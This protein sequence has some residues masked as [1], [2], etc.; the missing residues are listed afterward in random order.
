[1]IE[2]KNFFFCWGFG[3]P[4]CWDAGACAQ[5]CVG[6]RGVEKREFNFMRSMSKKKE[7]CF[8]DNVFANHSPEVMPGKLWNF[9]E[10]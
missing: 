10:N 8:P 6:E 1:M 3:W 2:E 4:S 7:K 9:R 5:A